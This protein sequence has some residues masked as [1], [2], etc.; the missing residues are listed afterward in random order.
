MGIPGRA[1]AL[2]ATVLSAA[3]VGAASGAQPG[4]FGY[5]SSKPIDLRD[6]GRHS[7]ETGAS[8]N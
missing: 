7:A 2:A 4:V 3:G 1:A 5:D 8:L 6:T